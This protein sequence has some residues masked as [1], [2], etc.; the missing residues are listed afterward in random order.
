[1]TGFGWVGFVGIIFWNIVIGF[2]ADD[3][4]SYRNHPWIMGFLHS[5]SLVVL[6]MWAR[7][8][9]NSK[10][11]VWMNGMSCIRCGKGHYDGYMGGLTHPCQ[12][13]GHQSKQMMT[14][15]QFRKIS[16][17]NKEKIRDN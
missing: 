2:F 16:R 5:Y 10:E 6:F 9:S 1:M 11:I 7:F 4:Q 8:F 17:R 12:K 14:R 3:Y 15:K 13:C